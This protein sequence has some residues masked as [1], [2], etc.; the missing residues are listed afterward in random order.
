MP[1]TRAPWKAEPSGSAERADLKV[2]PSK[3]PR[4]LGL[5]RLPHHARLWRR[6][7]Q[8]DRHRRAF[9]GRARDVDRA[10]VAIDGVELMPKYRELTPERRQV[11]LAN[12]EDVTVDDQ[13]VRVV[14]G[15][16]TFVD[17]A[18]HSHRVRFCVECALD[19]AAID[20]MQV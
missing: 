8:T 12:D 1:F 15:N 16:A 18:G 9:A 3:M 17:V 11:R 6:R 4:G 13:A 10:V 5:Y 2:R 20:P 14:N 19:E 7:R